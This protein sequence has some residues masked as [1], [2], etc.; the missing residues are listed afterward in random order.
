MDVDPEQTEAEIVLELE[1]TVKDPA[2][3]ETVPV[4]VRRQKRKASSRTEENEAESSEE[5]GAAKPFPLWLIL[6]PAALILMCLGAAATGL[7]L[8]F[9][10]A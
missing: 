6:V 9:L 1:R 4:V 7:V 5:E 3:F 2:F 8:Y 10:K